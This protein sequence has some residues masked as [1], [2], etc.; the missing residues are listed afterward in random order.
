MHG[1]KQYTVCTNL[2]RVNIYE[3]GKF[4]GPLLSLRRKVTGGTV[5]MDQTTIINCNVPGTL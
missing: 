2:N 3:F 4:G 1:N 5:L